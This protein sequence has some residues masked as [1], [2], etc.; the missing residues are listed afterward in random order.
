MKKLYILFLLF[1][2]ISIYL[3]RSS[4]YINKLSNNK[5]EEYSKYPLVKTS[6]IPNVI[7]T[8]WHSDKIPTFVK[9]CINSWKRHNP[10]YTI[11][12][13]NKKTVSDF[14]PFDIYKLKFAKT[15]QI[16]SDFIR[17]YLISTY[18]GFWLDSTIYLNKPLDWVHA[19]Q[20][21]E[22]SEFVGFK[23]GETHNL[24]KQLKNP[25]VE[26]WFLAA[27]PNSDFMK[28]WKET[29]YSL[30]DYKTKNEYINFIKSS[31]NIDG[32]GSPTYLVIHVA[33]QYVLQ[34]PKHNYKI[35]IL[36]AVKG[37]YLYHQT[38]SW[39]YLFV[40]PIFLYYKGTESPIV[41]YRGP[42]RRIIEY[43]QI[44]LLYK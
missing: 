11:H 28:D 27:I 40:I 12:I 17:L 19:Y 20:V 25:I 34:N 44:Y 42:E 30:N 32:I 41:K 2:L 23:I 1:V 21:N 10:T 14:I 16:I 43:S 26:S 35:S 22:N 39:N 9:K 5:F 33:C 7:Y 13:L 3:Y 4:Y 24:E 31:T 29:F 38:I 37:P 36:D 18:G 6:K 8:Y 15:Q